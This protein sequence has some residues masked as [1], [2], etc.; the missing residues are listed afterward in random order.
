MRQ[1]MSKVILGIY[2]LILSLG[3]IYMGTMMILG[4]GMFAEYP[5]EWLSK[6]PFENWIAPGLIAI[7][8]FGLGNII[9]AIFSFKKESNKSWA[10]SAIMGLTF[11]I[12]MIFQVILLQEWYMATV[13]FYIFSI[14]QLCLSGYVFLRYRKAS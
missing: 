8:I 2:D 1:K 4:N 7:V 9:A 3:A 10:L 14:I 6:V 12:S 11:F 13:E 5:K